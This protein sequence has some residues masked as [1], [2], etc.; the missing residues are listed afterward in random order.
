MKSGIGTK[1]VVI[2]A[3][4]ANLREIEASYVAIILG[5]QGNAL[6][7][8]LHRKIGTKNT[9]NGEKHACLWIIST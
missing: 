6:S 7:W 9:A 2:S 8:T 5:S 4:S 3:I 1:K